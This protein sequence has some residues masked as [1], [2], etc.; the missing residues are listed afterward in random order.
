MEVNVDGAFINSFVLAGMG[1]IF[2]DKV[3]TI[4]GG[5]GGSFL[6]SSAFMAE[7]SAL[8]KAVVMAISLNLPNVVFESDCKVLVDC[9]NSGSA[10]P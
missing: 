10:A 4:L 9:V 6:A 8:R 3:G 2:R 7:A 1:I 5:F